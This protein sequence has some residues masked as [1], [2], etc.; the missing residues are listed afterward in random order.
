MR[1][2]G[3]LSPIPNAE[4]LVPADTEA[5]LREL[6]TD[7]QWHEF[8]TGDLDFSF[9]WRK[10]AR[11]RGNVF[12][13]RGSIAIAMRMMPSEIPSF[14]QLGLPP[15]VRDFAK[16]SRGLV[17]VTGPTGSGKSTTLAALVDWINV[18]R[19][20]HVITIEDP[21]EYVH[22]HQ[23]AVIN[24]RAVGDDAETFASALRS[25]LREDP[26]VMLIGEMRDLESIQVAL[27]MAET[28]HLVFATLHTNDTA[29]TVD[30]LI[31]AF[32][33]DQRT[34]IRSQ[35][36]AVLTAVVYQRMLPRTGWLLM[37]TQCPG[38]HIR[39]TLPAPA[40]ADL[41]TRNRLIYALF[42]RR[43][44]ERAADFFRQQVLP[45]H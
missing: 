27:T 44:T 45:T 37:T 35:L 2:N 26:D 31:D 12:R 13:Q 18:N 9:T 39:V 43:S 30:R 17:L 29:Q 3:E 40:D 36:A 23:K 21:I 34:Q 19:A 8:E 6:L 5:M 7:S 14:D 10:L 25:A 11:I 33:G 24:Q 38:R 4:K 28:G 32:P 20:V 15:V 16:L 41:P 42:G 1:A 22:W